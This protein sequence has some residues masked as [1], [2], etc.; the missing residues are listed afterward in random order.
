MLV[1]LL[2]FLILSPFIGQVATAVGMAVF[3]V[4]CFIAIGYKV[5]TR[6]IWM[7]AIP[8]L[9]VL[10]GLL[11][12]RGH[13]LYDIF[14]DVWYFSFPMIAVT[15]GYM[16]ARRV[17]RLEPILRTAVYAGLAL[18]VWQIVQF[19][20]HRDVLTV[21]GVN[22]L[23]AETGNGFILSALAPLIVVVSSKYKFPIRGLNNT[24]LRLM[25][26]VVCL[27]AVSVSFSRT[28][29]I[30]LF[31]S[32]VTGVGWITRK[33][34]LG[35]LI[36]GPALLIVAASGLFLPKNGDS[37]F[38][39][40]A[41]ATD[42]LTYSDFHNR[43]D[44]DKYWRAYETMVA[45]RAFGQGDAVQHAV[46]MGF[47]TLVDVGMNIDLGGTIMHEIPIFHN[48]YV[49][50]IVKTGYCGLLLFLLYL[51][52]FYSRGA[53]AVD[54]PRVE[55]RLSGG[56]LMAL[57]TIVTCSAVVIGGWY[58]PPLFP[59]MMLMGSMAFF[60]EKGQTFHR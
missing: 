48:G 59:V 43:S 37:F 55:T 58:S 19:I 40:L 7:L 15:A 50:V 11:E 35:W 5:P 14:K 25:L 12:S 57:T 23:R 4:W 24:W 46:G 47:G 18:S 3:L 30:S 42:E 1:A 39:K 17:R 13:V 31:V 16:I 2:V 54:A 29:F 20:E 45:M 52:L 27:A 56:I 38:G 32:L 10:I 28:L 44:V 53:I 8:C 21:G 36:I 22:D 60:T 6:G 51:G 26:C 34:Q 33:R 41:S 49:Y 9:T